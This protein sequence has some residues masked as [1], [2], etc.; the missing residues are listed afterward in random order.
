MFQDA[1]SRFML[2]AASAVLDW[3][4]G[5]LEGTAVFQIHGRKDRLIPARAVEADELLPTAGHVL[6]M[7]HA[8]EVNDYIRRCCRLARPAVVG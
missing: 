6:N 8:G 3:R 7:T 5:P 2:W 4:P 1:D